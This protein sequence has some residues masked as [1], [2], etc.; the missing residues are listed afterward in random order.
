[1]HAFR[2]LTFSILCACLIALTQSC[3]FMHRITAPAGHEKNL[4][5]DT[6]RQAQAHIALGEYRKALERYAGAYDKYH[7]PD[8]RGSY[9]GAGGQIRKIADAAYQKKDFAEAGNVY[10]TLFESGIT[11]RDFADSLSFDDDYLNGQMKACSKGLLEAGLTT[12]REGNLEEAIAVWG[13]ALTFDR[14]NEEIKNM[15]ETATTQLQNLKNIQ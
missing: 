6:A 13:K 1:M 12:Y 4:V 5:D 7:Y 14:N 2:P 8:M 11:T 9:A 10:N 3:A 15:I